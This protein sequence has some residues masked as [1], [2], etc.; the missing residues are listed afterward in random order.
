VAA[1]SSIDLFYELDERR[2]GSMEVDYGVWWRWAND[3]YR[4]TWVAETGEL[5]AVRLG[6][7]RAQRMIQIAAHAFVDILA[8]GEP[9]QV[10]V[11]AVIDDRDQVERALE[12]WAEVCGEQGSLG[13]VAERVRGLREAPV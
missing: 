13:W 4:I 9:M 11:L 1:F 2:R 3:T 6:P 5:I 8:G 10:Y 7:L 12:G